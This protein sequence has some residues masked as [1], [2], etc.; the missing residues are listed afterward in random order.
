MK[1][2]TA[3]W[4]PVSYISSFWCILLGSCC[5]NLWESPRGCFHMVALLTMRADRIIGLVATNKSLLLSD[6]V[7]VLDG[8]FPWLPVCLRVYLP[9][10]VCATCM[11]VC[12]TLGYSFS[13]KE[14]KSIVCFLPSPW[15]A[16]SFYYFT[17]SSSRVHAATDVQNLS[18]GVLA[19]I[20]Q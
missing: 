1:E 3:M 4:P 12:T 5:F 10:C 16:I 18:Y 6:P 15:W 2:I 11:C 17:C 8:A 20:S 14:M 13:K 19:I 9:M 7:R